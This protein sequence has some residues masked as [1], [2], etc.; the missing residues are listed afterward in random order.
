MNKF[1]Q[2]NLSSEYL[3][4]EQ[5]RDPQVMV[6]S[7]SGENLGVLNTKEAIMLADREGLDLVQVGQKDELAITK[8]MNFGKFLY[9]KKKQLSESKKKQ[10]VV[11]IKEIKLR[12]NIGDQDYLT[13]LNQ[14]VKFLQEG[15]KVK[16]S[17]QFRGRELMMINELG[18]KF[19]E[20]IN[21]DLLVKNLGDMVEEKE[22][23]GKPFWSKIIYLK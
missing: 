15:K 17:L 19:F 5:I 3:V 14:M 7:S 13:K 10:K 21:K 4:N 8:I 22:Q 20:R 12:P 23:R 2:D 16:V 18:T 1:K 11:Q 9:E 6:I